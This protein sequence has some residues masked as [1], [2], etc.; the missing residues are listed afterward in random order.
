LT[1]SAPVLRYF[2]NTEGAEVVQVV[3]QVFE[4]EKYGVALPANSP[5]R[6]RI[7]Q[8][9]LRLQEDGTYQRIYNRWFG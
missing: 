5:L 4:P 1:H 2:V 8:A 6:E 3:G 9:I 7:N